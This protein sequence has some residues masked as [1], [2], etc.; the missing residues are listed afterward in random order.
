MDDTGNRS[1]ALAQ[2]VGVELID[3]D[4]WSSAAAELRY[5]STDPYAA[6]IVFHFA[7]REISWTLA[8]DLIVTGLYEPTGEGDVHVRP[9][10]DEQGHA[11]VLIELSSPH[12]RALVQ[13]RSRDV[14][15]F[16]EKITETVRPGTEL[17]YLDIDAAIDAL[18]LGTP[19]E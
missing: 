4:G 1:C 17:E 14:R 6:T 9:G 7:E 13:A 12:G 10:L 11:S 15:E 19:S 8:R 5:D 18:L 2:T 16:V 3:G